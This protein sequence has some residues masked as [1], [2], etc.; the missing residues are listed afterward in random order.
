MTCTSCPTC[1]DLEVIVASVIAG[2]PEEDLIKRIGL[3]ELRK[4]SL[5]DKPCL[6]CSLL[7]QCICSVTGRDNPHP[8]ITFTH[9]VIDPRKQGDRLG[10]GPLKAHLMPDRDLVTMGPLDLHF[11]TSFGGLHSQ[12]DPRFTG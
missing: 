8:D 3:A 12:R 11:H 2:L 5:R 9:L 1:S 4:E 6:S 7:W 10:K